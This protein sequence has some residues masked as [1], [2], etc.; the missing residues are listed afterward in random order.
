MASG[1]ATARPPV[2]PRVVE[3]IKRHLK[4]DRKLKRALDIGCGAGLSTAPLHTV[5]HQTIGLEPAEAM[6]QWTSTTAPGARFIVAAAERLPISDR[7]IDIATAAGSL[8]YVDLA[9]FFG[10]AQR[11]LVPRGLL[12]VY[13][14]SQ[15]RS[16]EDS[17]AL[18]RW[19]NEFMRR[20]PMP[21]NEARS[22]DP[23]TLAAIDWRFRLSAHETFKIA[24]PMDSGSYIEYMMTETNVAAAIRAG[25]V[26]SDVREWCV[27]TVGPVFGG[28]SREVFFRGYIA[29]LE[30]SP[31]K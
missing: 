24:L 16:F 30:P 27:E 3:R 22:L 25:A 18:D 12:I 17:P 26:L 15:G 4:I 1:Y 19:F 7:S 13:D 10:E 31:V 5:A 20:Y 9:P 2:H 23:E 11:V 29:Y 6:L 14:F 28:K 21:A 8:N